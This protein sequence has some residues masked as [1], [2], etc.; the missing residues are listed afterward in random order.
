MKSFSSYF[1]A[2]FMVFLAS[3]VWSGD[4]PSKEFRVLLFSKTLLYRHASITNGIQ[5][6]KQLG[7]ENHF[8]VD[9][10]EDSN[11]FTPQNLA[12]YRVVI[13]LSTSGDILNEKQQSAFQNY[14]E[15]GGGLAAIHA[16]V[17]GAVGTGGSW[18][19][20]GDV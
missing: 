5:A 1:L 10:T 9:A 11:E 3:A 19:W 20:E 4:L 18:P 13:F 14:I 2:L 15:M 8:I 6:I 7:A 12:Q 16:A 17:A